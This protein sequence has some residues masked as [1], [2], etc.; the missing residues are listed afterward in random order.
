MRLRSGEVE[1]LTQRIRHPL[2]EGLRIF[3]VLRWC[4]ENDIPA[5]F[6]FDVTDRQSETCGSRAWLDN[7]DLTSPDVG[8]SLIVRECDYELVRLRF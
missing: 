7:A 1:I 4:R 2:P 8:D 6:A 5:L 3:A